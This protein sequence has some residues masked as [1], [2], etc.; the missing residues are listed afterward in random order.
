MVGSECLEMRRQPADREIV[1]NPI[2]AFVVCL[3][4]RGQDVGLGLTRITALVA[5]WWSLLGRGRWGIWRED[6]MQDGRSWGWLY[7]IQGGGRD[8]NRGGDGQ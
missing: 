5:P 7:Q 8:L 2:V 6:M 3:I 4:R 1:S